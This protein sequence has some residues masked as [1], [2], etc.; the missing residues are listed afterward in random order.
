MTALW[1]AIAVTLVIV[2]GLSVADIIGRHL[3]TKRTTAWL[4]IVILLPFAGAVL[5][6]VL[7]SRDAAV[8]GQSS[9]SD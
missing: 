6:W 3:G 8:G 1:I 2:W 7:R 4:L 5:Y 9:A